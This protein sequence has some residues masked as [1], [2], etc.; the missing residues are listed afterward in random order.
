[1]D[2]DRLLREHRD[3]YTDERGRLLYASPFGEFDP[4]RLVPSEAEAERLDQARCLWLIAGFVFC[5]AAVVINL[6]NSWIDTSGVE[7]FPVSY[8]LQYFGM[9]RVTRRWTRVV[10]VT[11]P[12]LIISRLA[13]ETRA[14]LSFRILLCIG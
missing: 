12:E 4:V 10:D 5:I 11:Y 13:L 6:A 9:R 2:Q 7:W 8:I 3:F 14:S 1:M